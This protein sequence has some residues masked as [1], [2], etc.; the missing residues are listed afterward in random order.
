MADE[1][2]P[3]DPVAREHTDRVSDTD[4]LLD[5]AL[6]ADP[7]AIAGSYTPVQIRYLLLDWQRLIRALAEGRTDN[8][9]NA[10]R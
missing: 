9:V 2:K 5:W 10:R 7:Q 3:N 4:Y 1:T 8:P 6:N